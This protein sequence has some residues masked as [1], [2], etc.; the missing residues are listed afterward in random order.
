MLR[1]YYVTNLTIKPLNISK[2]NQ[3][4]EIFA[5][6]IVDNTNYF[7]VSGCSDDLCNDPIEHFQDQSIKGFLFYNEFCNT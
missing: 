5:T 2:Y 1:K 3:A 6:V 4:S 7:K